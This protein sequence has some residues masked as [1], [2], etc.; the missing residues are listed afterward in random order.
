MLKR[1]MFLFVLLFPAVFM[2][3]LYALYAQTVT[4]IDGKK[5]LDYALK[6]AKVTGN[7]EL[8]KMPGYIA[9]NTETDN[10]PVSS[11]SKKS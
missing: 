9:D 3:A 2:S 11:E 4:A 10:L 1:F 8:L 5:A 6:N 7:T